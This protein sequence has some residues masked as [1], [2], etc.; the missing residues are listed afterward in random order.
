MN[1][2]TPLWKRIR[3]AKAEAWKQNIEIKTVVASS[4]RPEKEFK[5]M[6]VKVINK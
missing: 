6:G 2:N 3:D 4:S 5:L 1:D